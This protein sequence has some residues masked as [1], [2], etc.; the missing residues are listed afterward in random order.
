MK[1]PLTIDEINQSNKNESVNVPQRG[2]NWS[3]L[4]SISLSDKKFAS[5][6]KNVLPMRIFSDHSNLVTELKDKCTE[7]SKLEPGWDEYDAVPVPIEIA[8]FA[9]G[10]IEELVKPH[11]PK[12][13][14]A[15]GYDGTI[16]IEWC[17]NNYELEIEII[18]PGE[19][20]VLMTDLESGEMEEYFINLSGNENFYI[21][22]SE[23]VNKLSETR[24]TPAQ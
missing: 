14:I 4:K 18:K 12:P 21:V 9:K 22:L 7:L 15:P 8:D 6:D 1:I 11:V 19:V 3:E 13:G 23:L 24:Q 20:E 17:E 5:V 10:I 16:Q 2:Q